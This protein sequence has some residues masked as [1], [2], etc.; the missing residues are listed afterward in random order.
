[1]HAPSHA[2]RGM[3]G[4][5]HNFIEVGSPGKETGPPQV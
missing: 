3:G 4:A 1:M 5:I 2:R